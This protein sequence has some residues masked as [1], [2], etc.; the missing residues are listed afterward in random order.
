MGRALACLVGAALYA[1]A[2]PPFGWSAL[3]WVALVPLLLAV[4]RSDARAAF[5]Y[6]LLFGTAGLCAVAWWLPQAVVRYVTLSWPL[7][8]FG[9]LAFSVLLMAPTVGLFAAGAAAILRGRKPLRA[10]IAVAAL[11]TATELFRARV[12]GQ[13]W[14]LLGHS[15]YGHPWLIQVAA[16]TGVYGISFLLALGNVAVADALALVGAGRGLPAAATTLALPAVL[17]GAVALGGAL[18]TPAGSDGVATWPVM[19]VQTNVPPAYRWTEAYAGRQLAAHLAVSETGAR[20]AHPALIVWPE[21]AVTQ[22]LE[23]QP[24]LAAQLATFARRHQA[25]LLFGVPRYADGHTY[26]STRLITAAGL[27]GGYY[28]KRHLVLFAERRPFGAAATERSDN[29]EHFTAGT[30]PGVLQSFVP[31]GVSICHEILYPELIRDDVR[32]GA[33]LL[34]NVSNDGWVDGGYGTAGPQHLA[35]AIFRAVETRR[36][37][38]RA[39][40]TGISGVIDPY[41]RVVAQLAAGSSGVVTAPVAGRSELTPYVR[42]GDAFAFGCALVAVAALRARRRRARVARPHFSVVPGA[43][44]Q[45]VG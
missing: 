32:A 27:N 1:L 6:G 21:H 43:V 45:P 28:D 35:M 18:A 15:Q 5:G 36:Y 41:G 8:L 33:A 31:V 12:L 20:G 16:V 22:Y 34:V 42:M 14:A 3:A 39:A 13:P 37:L 7:A 38:V 10:Q 9:L 25:D 40:T 26:N 24:V 29:P 30:V 2:L 17:T 11:W 23:T 19:V 4:R 44:A